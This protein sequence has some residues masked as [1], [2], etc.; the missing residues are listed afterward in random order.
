MAS[1]QKCQSGVD[2]LDFHKIA[3]CWWWWWWWWCSGTRCGC[4]LRPK[5]GLANRPN[6]WQR[7][8]NKEVF[9]KLSFTY[10]LKSE[11]ATRFFFFF[12]CAYGFGL[13]AYPNESA[14]KKCI[15][16]ADIQVH[17]EDWE[18]TCA[19]VVYLHV[20]ARKNIDI[21]IWCGLGKWPTSKIG[22][23]ILPK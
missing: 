18:N 4:V 3:D 21:R 23:I 22:S 6:L 1:E 5:L 16:C 7:G 11:L 19:Y 12:M 20:K 13:C 9:I 2:V 15:V 8:S 10:T 14:L 17:Y